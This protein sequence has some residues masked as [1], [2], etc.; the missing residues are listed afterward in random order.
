MP[1]IKPSKIIN[2]FFSEFLELRNYKSKNKNF[3][4]CT[5][6][7]K[8]KVRTIRMYNITFSKELHKNLTWCFLDTCH[9]NSIKLFIVLYVMDFRL[10]HEK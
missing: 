5:A 9:T 2:Y 10:E 8:N 1:T 4:V 7:E 3:C 6:S